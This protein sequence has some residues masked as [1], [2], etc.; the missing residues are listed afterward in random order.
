MSAF[1]SEKEGGSSAEEK[2]EALASPPSG[3][4]FEEVNW[5]NSAKH[6]ITAF[7]AFANR[8][9]TAEEGKFEVFKA[10][11]SNAAGETIHATQTRYRSGSITESHAHADDASRGST[12]HMDR[13][14]VKYQLKK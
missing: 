8:T 2:R 9:R 14:G 7:S 12:R 4:G 1:K 11:I 10:D 5:R 13:A 3:G 6:R